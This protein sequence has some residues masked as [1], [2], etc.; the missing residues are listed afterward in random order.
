MLPEDEEVSKDSSDAE[1]QE[2][3]LQR[4]QSNLEGRYIVHRFPF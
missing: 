3:F 2:E 1:T 4:L